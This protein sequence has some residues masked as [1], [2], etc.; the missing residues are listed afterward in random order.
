ML[1]EAALFADLDDI[2][3]GNWA[4]A[5]QPLLAERFS[6]SNHGHFPDWQ[7]VFHELPSYPEIHRHLC[8]GIASVDG[9]EIS[10]ADTQKLRELL[11]RLSPWRKGPFRIHGIDI[12]AEWRSNLKWQRITNLLAPLEGRNVLDVGCGNGYYALRM[13]GSGARLIIGV[14][15]T[16]LFVC[17]FLSIKK[18]FDVDA[19]HILPLRLEELPPARHNFDTTFSMGVLYHQRQPS[20]HLQQLMNTLRPGG[21]LVLETLIFPGTDKV[22]CE[23]QD[24]YARMRNVWHLPTVAALEDWLGQ[25]GFIN[26]RCVDV[27]ATTTAEQR[28]TPWMTYESFIESLDPDDS[29]KTVEGLPAPTRAVLICNTP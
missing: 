5:L 16:L 2:G 23:P 18:L 8:T 28:T 20:E 7:E 21:E 4:A 29:Q 3:L 19:M 25:A 27:T 26:I 17:Q 6:R 9:P 15:P 1:N 10:T 13:L 24:R 22:V 14:D 12:D 11:L